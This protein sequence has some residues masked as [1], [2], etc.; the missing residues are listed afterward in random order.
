MTYTIEDF[1]NNDKTKYTSY[2]IYSDILKK[3]D[4]AN[5]LL[6]DNDLDK[7]IKEMAEEELKTLLKQKENL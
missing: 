2:P 4:E 7:E 6:S 5:L 3:E 1:K